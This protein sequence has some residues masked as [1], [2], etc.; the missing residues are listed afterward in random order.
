LSGTGVTTQQLT[1]PGT[2]HWT[3][4][5]IPI[6]ATNIQ[7]ELG[8][9]ATPFEH[10]PVGLELGLCQRY[11]QKVGGPA[12]NYCAITGVGAYTAVPVFFVIE[13]RATPTVT[14]S[15]SPASTVAEGLTVKGF[16]LAS[17]ATSIFGPLYGSCE[18]EL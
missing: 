8:T 2:G 9:V 13:M 5:N 16:S 7:L 15:R 4:P 18:S 17:T 14:F 12:G 1:A 3:L 10:R 6:T 11:Y